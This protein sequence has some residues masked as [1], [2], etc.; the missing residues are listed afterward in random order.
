[1]I[2]EEIVGIDPGLA[3]CGVVCFD[4]KTGKVRRWM[5]FQGV[6]PKKRKDLHPS[7]RANII[8]KAAF[9][10]IYTV[11]GHKVIAV[12]G[13]A[14]VKNSRSV[15]QM[16]YCRQA[17]YDMATYYLADFTYLVISP[18]RAK[19]AMTGSGSATKEQVM[20]FVESAFGFK[21]DHDCIGDAAAIGFA[22]YQHFRLEFAKSQGATRKDEP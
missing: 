19:R 9:E 10:F 14:F 4:A 16:A 2:P 3:W 5:K 15:E 13:P 20:R 11:P 17:L 12:E 1:M 22:A 18:T 7:F 21:V 6:P 8:A